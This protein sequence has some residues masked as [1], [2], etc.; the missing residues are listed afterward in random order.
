MGG[1]GRVLADGRPIGG[2]GICSEGAVE[3]RDFTREGVE[4]QVALERSI[5]VE[6]VD[7]NDVDIGAVVVTGIAPSAYRPFSHRVGCFFTIQ[8]PGRPRA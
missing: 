6:C 3:D 5:P 4:M 8:I 2:E 1:R 7:P